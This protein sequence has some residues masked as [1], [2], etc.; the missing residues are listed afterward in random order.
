MRRTQV[1][2][3]LFGAALVCALSVAG[4]A[5]ASN[6]TAPVLKAPHK[7]AYVNPGRITLKVYSPGLSGPSNHIYVQITR[8]RKLDKY[9][10]LATCISASKGCAYYSLKHWKGHRGW[11]ILTNTDPGFPGFWATTKGTYYWQ[12][13]HVA[14]SSQCSTSNNCEVASRIQ[15]FHVR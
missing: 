5:V 1:R 14:D 9:G 10:N 12:A 3:M 6:F 4:V 7:N 8:H 15:K 13:L 11:W 2:L